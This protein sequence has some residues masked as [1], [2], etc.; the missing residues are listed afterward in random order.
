MR[1]RI[2][3]HEGGFSLVELLVVI[4]MITVMMALAVPPYLS[5]QANAQYRQAANAIVAALRSARSTAIATNRQVQLEISGNLYRT[6]T[7]N[8]AI[9]STVWT[10][11]AW[12]N[13]PTGVGLNSANSRSILNPNG[14]ILFANSAV[15]PVFTSNGTELTIFVQDAAVDPAVDKFGINLRQTGKVTLRTI[16]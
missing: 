4:A 13:V 10:A 1:T 8:R 6:A 11:G 7:G 14:T 5:W 12:I 2:W 9:A 15:D 3:S 16:N